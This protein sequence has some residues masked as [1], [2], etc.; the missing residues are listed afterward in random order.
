MFPSL[1]PGLT[2]SGTEVY[3]VHPS[4]SKLESYKPRFKV[5]ERFHGATSPRRSLKKPPNVLKLDVLNIREFSDRP[6]FI[7]S[8]IRFRF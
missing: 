1:G 2:D 5:R 7:K 4:S 3:R 8:V 6:L